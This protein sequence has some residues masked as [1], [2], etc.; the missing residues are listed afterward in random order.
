LLRFEQVGSKLLLG[1]IKARASKEQ[2][3]IA[4]YLAQREK[5][6]GEFEID[7]LLYVAATRA[8]QVL[9][10]VADLTVSAK[11]VAVTEPPK[12]SLLERLWSGWHKESIATVL[13]SST[14]EPAA[15]PHHRGGALI[16]RAEVPVLSEGTGLLVQTMATTPRSAQPTFNAAFAWPAVKSYERVLG[17]LIHAWLDHLGRQGAAQW[18][19]EKLL[20]QRQRVERQCLQ[21]G[22]PAPE[23][24]KAANEVLETLVAMLS[25]ERGQQLLSQLGARREWALLDESGKVSVLDLAVQDER[26]WLV[27]DYKTGRP[28]S[29]E[30]PEAFG[31]R[32]LARYAKQLQSYCDQVTGF[33]GQAARAALYFPRDDLWFE[34]DPITSDKPC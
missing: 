29:S 1:P 27:V 26:G 31:Q 12:G 6:R 13:V 17:T 24:T 22:V 3:P 18:P 20:A 2:D 16:R 5:R 21:A 14:D 10:L 33:D 19:V 28:L 11:D 9:H 25:V 30:T 4:K 32:M 15:V 8:K 34:F 23:V 7:R